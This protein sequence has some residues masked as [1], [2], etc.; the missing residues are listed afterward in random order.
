MTNEAHILMIDN[1][2]SDIEDCR[3]AF[4]KE[5]SI[6]TAQDE[7]EC[8]AIAKKQPP[9]LILLHVDEGD[10]DALKTCRQL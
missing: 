2:G 7:G 4:G 10:D 6:L 8:L 1:G 5:Y 9:D 3:T